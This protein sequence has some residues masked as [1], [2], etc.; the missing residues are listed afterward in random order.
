MARHTGTDGGSVRS[1]QARRLAARCVRTLGLLLVFGAGSAAAE[2]S[3]EG[4]RADFERGLLA[5][6]QDRWTSALSAFSAAYRVAPEPAVLFN[7]AGAQLRCG[8]L[9]ASNTN[10]RRLLAVA[11]LTRAEHAAV[12]RQLAMI[13]RR[14][15]RLRVHIDGL[16]EGD[17]ILLDKVRLYPDELDR[18]MWLDP[19]HHE[20]L[21]LRPR[22]SPHLRTLTLSESE[23]R[24]LAL[25]LP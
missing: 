18:D 7:L 20:L 13:E 16:H 8:K 5:A 15:P 10:Y 23:V 11:D 6:Q 24:V 12:E 21:V 1:S 17:R 3:L 4:A 19:G 9:L 22:A 25:G 2:P 14:M